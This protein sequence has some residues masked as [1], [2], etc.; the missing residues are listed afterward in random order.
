MKE[1][2][3]Y[4]SETYILSIHKGDQG[5]LVTGMLSQVMEVSYLHNTTNKKFVQ[6]LNKITI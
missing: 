1:T 3:K 2:S 6:C 4:V 5:L